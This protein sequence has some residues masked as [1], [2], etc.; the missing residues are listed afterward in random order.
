MANACIMVDNQAD[1]GRVVASSQALAMPASNLL[2]PHPSERWRALAPSAWAVLRKTA[3]APADTVMLCGLTCGPNATIR[4]RLSSSDSLG[5]AADVLDTGVISSGDA[6]FDIAYGSFVWRL[7][8]PAAWQFTRVDIDDPD[9]DFVE[10]G[11]I[12]DGLAESFDYNFVRGGERQW[13]DRSRVSS[14]SSGMTLTWDDVS[15]RRLNLSF[16]FI[17]LQQKNGLIERLDRVKGRRRN[18]LFIVDPDSDNLP[19]DSVYGLVTDL[20]P[21]SFGPV[22]DIFGKQFRIDERI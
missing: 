3:L 1:G 18:V 12:A 19:R 11:C 7:P 14:T 17:S 2:N 8:A 6:H 13:V 22:N 20:T 16:D 21:V 5:V 9:A 4:L 10:A 15:F